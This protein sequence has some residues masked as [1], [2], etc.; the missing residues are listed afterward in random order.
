MN[1]ICFVTLVVLNTAFAFGA[2]SRGHKTLTHSNV[3]VAIKWKYKNFPLEVQLYEPQNSL[4]AKFVGQT[5]TVKKLSAAKVGQKIQNSINMPRAS[6][7]SAVMV[8]TNNTKEDVYFFAVPH[9]VNPIEASVG[10]EF[11]CLCKNH[12]FHV[13]AGKIWYRVIKIELNSDFPKISDF[14]IEHEIVGISKV[15]ATT[16]YKGML[17]E[18]I[19]IQ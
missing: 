11:T 16:K 6:S 1:Q 18:K 19:K 4:Q 17:Y 3:N 10:Q 8:V 9:M 13:P 2:D 7:A 12:V 15:D 14:A 5:R